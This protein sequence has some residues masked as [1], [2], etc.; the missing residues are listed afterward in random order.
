VILWH[1]GWIEWITDGIAIAVPIAVTRGLQEQNLAIGAIEFAGIGLT[2]PKLAKAVLIEGDQLIEI[3]DR[4]GS[5]AQD[6][7]GVNHDRR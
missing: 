2:T 7:V 3:R 4:G 1:K 6:W 5:Q